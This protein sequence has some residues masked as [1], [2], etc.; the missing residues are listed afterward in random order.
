VTRV[1]RCR[2]ILLALVQKQAL[3][4]VLREKLGDLEDAVFA[5]VVLNVI[6]RDTGIHVA[7]PAMMR[8]EH[9]RANVRAVGQSRFDSRE[10]AQIR[11][12]LTASE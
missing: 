3:D 5:D 2:E 7:V 9:I 10:I 1:Q 8:V 12:A 4:A 6:L 11:Q